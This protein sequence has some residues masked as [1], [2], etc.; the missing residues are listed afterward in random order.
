MRTGARGNHG[1]AGMALAS[2]PRRSTAVITASTQTS[3][4]QLF[5]IAG[6]AAKQHKMMA[7]AEKA[8]SRGQGR[9]RSAR[10]TIQEVRVKIVS[11]AG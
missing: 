2:P 11:S 10:K 1:H 4:S 5:K 6:A 9:E 3:V 7:E 8:T